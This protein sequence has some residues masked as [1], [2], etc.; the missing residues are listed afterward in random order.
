MLTFFKRE[1]VLSAIA[2]RLTYIAAGSLS[3]NVRL[4]F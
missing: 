4:Q 2:S 3:T 1:G